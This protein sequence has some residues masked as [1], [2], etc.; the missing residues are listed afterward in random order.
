MLWSASVLRKEYPHPVPTAAV[1]RAKDKR[2]RGC[3]YL[4]RL[5]PMVRGPGIAPVA[6]ILSSVLS[7][8]LRIAAASSRVMGLNGAIAC[9]APAHDALWL[10]IHRDLSSFT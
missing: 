8:T 9:T 2:L 6:I 4:R 5:P 1:D 7:D 10:C 3:Q